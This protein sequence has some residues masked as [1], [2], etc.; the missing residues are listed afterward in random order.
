LDKAGA[1][2]L[3]RA[4]LACAP[5]SPSEATPTTRAEGVPTVL[6]RANAQASG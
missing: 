6:G 2:R 3:L 5:A 1:I 4:V